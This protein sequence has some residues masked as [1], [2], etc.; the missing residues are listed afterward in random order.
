[1]R[2]S[3]AVEL[4]VRLEERLVVCDAVRDEVRL[5]LCERERVCVALG[6][7]LCDGVIV[8]EGERLAVCDFDAVI[9]GVFELERL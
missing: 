8:S 6:V 7:V 5:E 4:G 9:E 1:M 3:V 2:E